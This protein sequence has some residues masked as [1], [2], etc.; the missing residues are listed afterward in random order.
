MRA[1]LCVLVSVLAILLVIAGFWLSGFN[2]DIRGAKA[3]GC[4]ISALF[5][6]LFCGLL[7]A[8]ITSDMK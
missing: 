5:A 6:G 7:T 8:A 2:F 3:V 1:V 4:F